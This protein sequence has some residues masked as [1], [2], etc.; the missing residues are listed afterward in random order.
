MSVCL[1]VDTGGPIGYGKYFLLDTLNG[2]GLAVCNGVLPF[3][4]SLT[5][6]VLV[7]YSKS[8]IKKGDYLRV[9]PRRRQYQ[10]L[11]YSII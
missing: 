8:G 10:H 6:S 11:D 4:V 3:R 9:Y 7:S 1:F 2:L 5:L